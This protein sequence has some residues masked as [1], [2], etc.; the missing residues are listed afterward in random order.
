MGIKVPTVRGDRS[1]GSS[2]LARV[3]ESKRSKHKN[4]PMIDPVHGRFDSKL[5]HAVFMGLLRRQQAGEIRNLRRQVPFELT[6]KMRAPLSGKPVR[7][8]HYVADFVY[9]DEHGRTRVVDAKGQRTD[10]YRDK[11]KQMIDRHGIEVEEVSK[12]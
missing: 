11:W 5:E 2:N 4:I 12:K 8:S 9:E 7:P 1:R 10:H 6:P 3:G